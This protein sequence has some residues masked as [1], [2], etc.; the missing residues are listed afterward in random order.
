MELCRSTRLP[1]GFVADSVKWQYDG[2]T[3]MAPSVKLSAGTHAITA[4]VVVPDG[5]EMLLTL[6]IDVK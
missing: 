1:E 5:N 2:N 3:V 6:E 4:K